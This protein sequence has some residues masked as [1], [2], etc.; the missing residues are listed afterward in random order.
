MASLEQNNAARMGLSPSGGDCREIM[1]RTV[2]AEAFGEGNIGMEAVAW[3]IRNRAEKGGFGG[4]SVGEVCLKDHQFEPWR[5]PAGLARI[6]A[7]DENSDNYRRVA[8]IVDRVLASD[9]S[10]DITGGS[11]HFANAQ[12]VRERRNGAV[13]DWMDEFTRQGKSFDLGR[14]TFYGGNPNQARAAIANRGNSENFTVSND[15]GSLFYS[16]RDRQDNPN[17]VYV[18]NDNHPTSAREE[19]DKK[20]NDFLGQLMAGFGDVAGSIGGFIMMLFAAALGARTQQEN[21]IQPVVSETTLPQT[22]DHSQ[23]ET[24]RPLIPSENPVTEAAKVAAAQV[25]I[26]DGCSIPNNGVCLPPEGSQSTPVLSSWNQNSFGI[27]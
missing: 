21:E 27:G 2:Y 15:P 18:S 7:L 25:T 22:V 24:S 26:P 19:S 6:S 13:T 23:P 5:S 16:G 14:H 3:V 9:Q 4:S 10:A 11:T 1:I 20:H 17:I 8:A 12:I